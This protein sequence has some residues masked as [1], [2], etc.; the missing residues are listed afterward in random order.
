M[1]LRTKLVIREIDDV[2]KELKDFKRG[3]F[4]SP[5]LFEIN[6]KDDRRRDYE[7]RF[8]SHVMEKALFD[9]VALEHAERAY[10]VDKLLKARS[11]YMAPNVGDMWESVA[12]KKR[13]LQTRG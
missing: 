7:V 8:A 5:T 10:E 3:L 1:Q 6:P 9:A 12:N 4:K 2:I 11:I 13:R